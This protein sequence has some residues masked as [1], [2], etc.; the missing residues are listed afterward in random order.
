MTAAA[1]KII[2]PSA[3]AEKYSAFE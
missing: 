3:P 2:I 1:M